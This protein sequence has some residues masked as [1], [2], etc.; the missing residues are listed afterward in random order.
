MN[1]YD[2]KA[3][4]KAT[5]KSDALADKRARLDNKLSAEDLSEGKRKRLEKARNKMDARVSRA[6]NN[7]DNISK[8]G[9]FGAMRKQI[10]TAASTAKQTASKGLGT[11]KATAKSGMSRAQSLANT[12]STNAK[13]AGRFVNEGGVGRIVGA[14]AG[15]VANGASATANFCKTITSEIKKGARAVGNTVSNGAKQAASYTARTVREAP[16]AVK[17]AGMSSIKCRT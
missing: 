6:N 3:Y 1:K 16:V 4:D 11:A 15:H 10:G 13:K 8:Y 5:A 9:R 12:A 17:K 14:G 2:A 7:A